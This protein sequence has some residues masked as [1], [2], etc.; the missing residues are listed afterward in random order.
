VRLCARGSRGKEGRSGPEPERERPLP[1]GECRLGARSPIF[2]GQPVRVHWGMP[3][4]AAIEGDEAT[5]RAAFRHALSLISRRIDGFL[6]L[7]GSA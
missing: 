6:A 7:D 1:G 5:K 4:P 2:P 3:D